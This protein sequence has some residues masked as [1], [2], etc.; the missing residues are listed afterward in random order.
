M[1]VIKK[2]SV[3]RQITGLA[4][5]IALLVGICVQ[6]GSQAQAAGLAL[7][8]TV[9][10]H[11]TSA[12][13]LTSPTFTTTQTN[14]LLVAFISAAGPSTSG[15]QS[16]TS[17]TGAGATWTLAKRTNTQAGTAEVWIASAPAIV[18]NGTVKATHGGSAYSGSITVAT[19]SGAKTTLGATASASAATGA[20]SASLTSTQ[21]GS[22]VWGVG[23]DWDGQTARTVGANQTKVDEFLSSTGD[24]YW[25]QRQAN[26]GTA[27]GTTVT[28]NDTAPTNHRWNLT[29]VEILPANSDTTAPT[30]PGAVTATATSATQATISWTASTD[31]VGVTGYTVYRSTT[32]G[33]TPSAATLVASLGN[34]A[35]FNDSNLA[36][37][38]YYY[39]VT[40]K[41]AAGNVSPAS[42]QGSLTLTD[43]TA[44]SAPS[45][46]SATASNAKVNLSWTAS[47]DNVGV[48]G[49]NVYRS[50]TSGFNPDA[51]TLLGTTTTATYTDMSVPEGT[52]YY[53]VIA[54]D[55]ASNAS[56]KSNEAS[57][58]V[59]PSDTT[60]PS[61]PD[62]LTAT[63]TSATQVSLTWN[64]STDNV[65]VA[66][67]N[68]YRSTTSGFTPDASSLIGTATSTTFTN[69]VTPNSYYYAVLAYDAAGNLSPAS[70]VAPI[71]IADTTAP[72]TPTNLTATAASATQV[73]LGWSVSTD[74][75]A[76]T[77]YNVYRNGVLIATTTTPT[78]S[79]SGLTANTTYAYYVVAVDAAGNASTATPTV[80]ATTLASGSGTV[81]FDDEF[82]GTALDTNAWTPGNRPGDASNA[83]KQC[84]KPGNVSVSGGYLR[85]LSKV[86]SSCSGFAY[87]SGMIQWNTFNYTYGTLEY[88]V[89]QPGGTGTWPAQWLLGY[90]CQAAFKT[91]DETLG[92]CN[93][94]TA[95]SDEIDATEIKSTTGPTVDWQNVISGNSGFQTCKPTLSNVTTNWHTY[96]LVWKPGSLVWKVDGVQ[97]CS[98]SKSIP[99]TAM[100]MIINTAL[101]GGGG[102]TINNSTL[103]QTMLVDYVKLTQ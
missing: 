17:V 32:A 19:F 4:L 24:T 93:W 8:K 47:T 7:D 13:S 79:N 26:P 83:E 55:A 6:L 36:P 44:P 89:L 21:T 9:S 70:N 51:S 60:A 41:D 43:T 95:G 54:T 34:V 69:T 1:K 78:Y 16:F 25:V 87:T 29:T 68:V 31:N 57:A 15:S 46:V 42:N 102:G 86:D 77:G 80:N 3:Y 63:Q 49:Y 98:F 52:Y 30:S 72:T 33:F 97:T 28:I 85:L 73:N 37:G 22:W 92:G 48:T 38:T 74:N 75:V 10:T 62:T 5:S 23:N 2:R 76:V 101:G 94:P 53:T 82:N 81:V 14:E 50:T 40:A 64:A 20:P 59:L 91:T 12:T 96:Q 61:A 35:S 103:P 27:A 56:S 11:S 99:S 66:G 84:Y 67:Y 100:F 65:S 88:R 18:T 39:V 90:K 45:N 58:V 71:V